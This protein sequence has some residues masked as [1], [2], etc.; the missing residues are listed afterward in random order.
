MTLDAAVLDNPY[1]LHD[2]LRTAAPVY[3]D[4]RFFG[5]IL[6]R[7]DDIVAVLKEAASRRGG[8]RPTN[9]CLGRS[10]LLENSSASFGH[11]RVAGC[12]IS[13]LLNTRACDRLLTNPSL[14]QQLRAC[15]AASRG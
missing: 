10:P 14:P 6:T 13:P 9:A 4:R 2:E 5:C 8:Q 3:R 15:G 7:Y 1:P 11:F 12:S